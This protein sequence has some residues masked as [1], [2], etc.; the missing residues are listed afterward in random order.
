MRANLYQPYDNPAE[1]EGISDDK[2]HAGISIQ[3]VSMKIDDEIINVAFSRGLS[4]RGGNDFIISMPQTSMEAI[5][6]FL[7]A[8]LVQIGVAGTV[9][10]DAEEG[11][12]RI[13]KVPLPK[14]KKLFLPPYVALLPLT[15]EAFETFASEHVSG[16]LDLEFDEV[17]RY[18]LVFFDPNGLHP[19][20]EGFDEDYATTD[21]LHNVDLDSFEFDGLGD[22]DVPFEDRPISQVDDALRGAYGPLGGPIDPGLAIGAL[23]PMSIPAE[24]LAAVPDEAGQVGPAMDLQTMAGPFEMTQEQLD[25]MRRE[26]MAWD[27]EIGADT[28]GFGGSVHINERPE[29]EDTV[30]LTPE[31]PT[32]DSLVDNPENDQDK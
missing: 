12:G 21:K 28:Q 26:D 29:R 24:V 3:S 17:P 18:T 14:Y 27:A 31:V 4:D 15:Q 23:M 20:E 30:I 32:G 6:A 22:E 13:I 16:L 25:E 10:T 1:G 7:N 5:D 2:Y 19:E 9:L 11:L 8:L